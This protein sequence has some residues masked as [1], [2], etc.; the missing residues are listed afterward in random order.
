M[1]VHF[2][3][4]VNNKIVEDKVFALI[5]GHKLVAGAFGAFFAAAALF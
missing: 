2:L 3:D 4:Y 1:H 5:G